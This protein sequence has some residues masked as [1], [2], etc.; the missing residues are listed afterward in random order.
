MINIINELSDAHQK[1]LKEENVD[2]ITEILMKKLQDMVNKKVQDALKKY[3]DSTNKKLK[4]REDF[5]KLQSE[6]K[7]TIKK[8]YMK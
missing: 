2:K 1:T 5:N 7:E 8:R 3:Q 6:T 4:L